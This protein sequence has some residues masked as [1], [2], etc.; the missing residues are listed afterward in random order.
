MRTE[1]FFTADEITAARRYGATVQSLR[2]NKTALTFPSQ[3]AYEAWI[4]E[5]RVLHPDRWYH[6]ISIHP[7]KVPV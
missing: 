3:A 4:E 2:Y 5:Q 1:S 6:A 7:Q